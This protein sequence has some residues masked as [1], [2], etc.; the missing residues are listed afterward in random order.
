M[1]LRDITVCIPVRNEEANIG[2]CLASL[3]GFDKVV[4][5]D[6][7]STDRTIA[8]AQE[9]GAEI[10]NFVWDG[11]F[12][13]KRNWALRNFRFQTPWVLFL[14][15]DELI[16]TEFIQELQHVLPGTAHNGFWLTY[17]NFFMGRPLR[18]GVPQ[19]K[20][21]LFRV[22]SGEYERIEENRWSNFDME[23]HE[24][25]Q[26]SGSVGTLNSRIL[27]HDYKSLWH[28]VARHN[29]YSSWETHRALDILGD[30]VRWGALTG[31]QKLKYRMLGKPGVPL[32]YFVYSYVLRGGFLDGRAGLHHAL[33]KAHYFYLIGQKLRELS[34]TAK[35]D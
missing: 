34:G 13:K 17:T 19:R 28:Y 14:D 29:E 16:T 27:H 12:P 22:G 35:S 8:I 11:R 32:M 9:A 4:L 7:G 20:L 15:A 2:R 21:A 25:P 6:S 33:Q 1:T 30:G 23:I 24:H 31:R 3:S 5:V 10:L 18:F 26:I